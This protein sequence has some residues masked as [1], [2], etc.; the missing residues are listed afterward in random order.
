M[1]GPHPITFA[2]LGHIVGLHR[3]DERWRVT[4]D[5]QAFASFYSEARARTAGRVE[6]RRLHHVASGRRSSR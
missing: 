1:S 5:G 6:A 4:I 2:V 3:L